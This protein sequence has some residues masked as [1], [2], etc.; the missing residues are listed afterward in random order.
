M[1]LHYVAVLSN[2]E[3]ITITDLKLFLVFCM[4]AYR[5]DRVDAATWLTKNKKRLT[6]AELILMNQMFLPSVLA[7][8]PNW[9]AI[10]HIFS[11]RVP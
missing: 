8:A 7:G 2:G 9:K 3:N 6:K 5:W 4:Y 11:A 1:M 10:A